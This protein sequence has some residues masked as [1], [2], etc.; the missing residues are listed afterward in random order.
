MTSRT[1]LQA[2]VREL[3]VEDVTSGL[4]ERPELLEVRDQRGRNWLHL[5]ASIDVTRKAEPK[6]KDSVRLAAALLNLGLGINTPAFTEGT[7]HATPLWYAVARG[8]NR[9]LAKFLLQSGST[10]E[11]CLWAACFRED[12]KMLQLL[13]GAGAPLEAV[14]EGETPLLGAVKSSKFKAARLLLDAGSNP[15][16][17]DARGMTALHYMLKKSSDK[18]HFGAFAQHGA[19]GDIPNADGDTAAALLRRKRDPYLRELADKLAS[20]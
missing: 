16:F 14:A 12:L 6:P 8:R 19:R 18:K 10:P 3:R 15:D 5:C 2:L 1:R 11:H 9:P 20:G 13:V 7:W 4:R 17:Q